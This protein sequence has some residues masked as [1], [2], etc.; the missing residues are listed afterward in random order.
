MLRERESSA[1]SQRQRFTATCTAEELLVLQESHSFCENS[2]VGCV[3]LSH[4]SS[5]LC[6]GESRNAAQP[7]VMLLS[8]ISVGL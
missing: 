8:L 5:G 3:R 7:K 2:A 4:L 6:V 1:D